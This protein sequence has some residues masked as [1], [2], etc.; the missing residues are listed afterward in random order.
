MLVAGPCSSRL[1]VYILG[2][3][4]VS[5]GGSSMGL[6]LTLSCPVPTKTEPHIL[7]SVHKPSCCS[8][9][10][11]QHSLLCIVVQGSLSKDGFVSDKPSVSVVQ[12]CAVPTSVFAGLCHSHLS[13]PVHRI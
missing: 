12:L 10:A 8:V 1:W 7:G 11:A 6:S 2:C 13:V 5:L 9:C 3:N 4:T